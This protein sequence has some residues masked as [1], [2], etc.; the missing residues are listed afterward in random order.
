MHW[1]LTLVWPSLPW[2]PSSLEARLPTT[3][4]SRAS[5]S[6]RATDFRSDV[7]KL[8]L[9]FHGKSRVTLWSWPRQSTLKGSRYRSKKQQL[10][11]GDG[12]LWKCPYLDPFST[13]PVGP[14]HSRKPTSICYIFEAVFQWMNCTWKVS[15]NSGS[16]RPDSRCQLC[17]I[18]AT[19]WNGGITCLTSVVV[20]IKG[21]KTRVGGWSIMGAE[22]LYKWYLGVPD[23][24]SW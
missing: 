10:E 17:H 3:S 15:Q 1:Q 11:G 16:R 8:A 21:D 5:P 23:W 9:S 6:P 18:T 12:K 13:G 20:R 2:H 24:L 7:T 14:K 4:L 22:S 19:R